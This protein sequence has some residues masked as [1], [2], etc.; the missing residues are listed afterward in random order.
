MVHND[1]SCG[2]TAIADSFDDPSIVNTDYGSLSG[3]SYRQIVKRIK[4]F[5][6]GFDR[7]T[8]G[9]REI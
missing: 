3:F 6:F 5:G 4:A 2:M 7:Q 8:A 9:S 1:A